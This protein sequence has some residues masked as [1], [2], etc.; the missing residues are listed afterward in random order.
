MLGNG[1]IIRLVAMVSFTTMA[2]F[3]LESL[4]TICQMGTEDTQAPMAIAT[5]VFGG[6]TCNMGKVSRRG[7]KK[8]LNTRENTKWV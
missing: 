2:M 3:M 5:K 1:S 8:V 4:Q 7:S 6:M